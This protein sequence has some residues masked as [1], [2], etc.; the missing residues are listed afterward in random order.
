MKRTSLADAPCPIAR[1]LDAVGEWWSLLILRDAMLG[2]TRFDEFQRGIGLATNM[3]A[4]RLQT[5]VEAGLLERRLYQPRPPRH[6]YHL[7]DK[8]RDF[9]PVLLAMADWGNRWLMPEGDF[10]LVCKDTGA[11]LHPVLVDRDSGR[12]IAAA[13]V[14]P[15]MTGGAGARDV[16]TLHREDVP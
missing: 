10:R 4:R 3:L 2:S 5:L 16:E 15:E 9:L 8:G 12:P 1:S 11:T 14:T 7:T 13:R 6:E